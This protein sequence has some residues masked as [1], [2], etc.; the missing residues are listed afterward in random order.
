MQRQRTGLKVGVF[1]LV[2]LL[3]LAALVITFGQFRFASTVTY[4]A[5]F[6]S[7]SR[8]KPGQDVRIAGIVVGSVEDIAIRDGH[9]SVTFDVNKR[10]TL[11]T[12]TRAV[13][14][15]Q[16]LIGNRYLEITAGPGEL[17]KM[18]PGATIPRANT[19]PALDLDTLLGGL[20]PVL[21]GL[22]STKVNEVSNAIIELLQGNGGP[23]SD[24]LS[25]TAS[26]TQTLAAR[27]QLIG[28]V[29]G[30]LNQVLSTV[31]DKSAQLDT[32]VN[33]LQQLVSKLAAG[34]DPIAGAVAPLASAET[35][36]TQMLA[37]SR[38]PI[39]GVLENIRPLATALDAR[40]DEIN[41]SIDPLGE[42]YLRLSAL[43]AY[44]AFFN[45]YYCSVKLKI[46][47]PAGSDILIPAGG[48]PDPTKGRCSFAK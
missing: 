45:F 34:R 32:S 38:R 9:A 28:N 10:Y 26:F 24:V 30:H 31:D 1:T 8:L 33:Q 19:Q 6:A 25:S 35:D 17:H 23:L 27:D 43:G 2:M 4:H 12:S 29:I 46:N 3:V 18:S 37:A 11:Y 41:K 14:R 39:Q 40:K 15:Y 20:R 44:G 16:D 7:V 48:P 13:I 21:K 5:D 36:L 47:G 22:D 42:D